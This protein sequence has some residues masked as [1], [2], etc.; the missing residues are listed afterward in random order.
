M[1]AVQK[2][3]SEAALWITGQ[4]AQRIP[5]RLGE[6]TDC[7]EAESEAEAGNGNI[8]CHTVA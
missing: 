4:G 7:G 1:P 2:V 6:V 5:S 8:M 3:W